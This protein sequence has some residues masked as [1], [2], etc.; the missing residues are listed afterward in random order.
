MAF[1][2][3]YTLDKLVTVYIA[4]G[5]ESSELS[6]NYRVDFQTMFHM[7]QCDGNVEQRLMRVWISSYNK[8]CLLT[9]VYSF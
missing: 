9:Q 5:P 3:V 7:Q 8:T 1:R 4:S 2:I 6:G